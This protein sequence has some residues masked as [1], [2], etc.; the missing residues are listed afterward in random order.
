[1]TPVHAALD[2][3]A[4]DA[5]V[6]AHA[7]AVVSRVEDLGAPALAALAPKVHL[8]RN[9]K[10]R[11]A[12]V[13]HR[14]LEARWDGVHVARLVD[15]AS[16]SGM[17]QSPSD[18]RGLQ[19]ALQDELSVAPDAARTL[20]IK[21]TRTLIAEAPVRVPAVPRHEVIDLDPRA[22]PDD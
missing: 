3:R 13:A 15:D 11:A 14:M 20:A 19:E 7:D 17:P 18:A 2:E 5:L 1:M 12:E 16:A 6:D 22:A 8:P 21:L 4:H 9:G 10:R